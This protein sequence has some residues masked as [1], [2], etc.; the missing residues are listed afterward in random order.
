MKRHYPNHPAV[1]FVR[2]NRIMSY[3]IGELVHWGDEDIGTK[4]F[5]VRER[6]EKLFRRTHL[7]DVL[8]R[9]NNGSREV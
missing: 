7:M 2:P 9:L 3:F 8:A 1:R 4:V 6:C 5:W